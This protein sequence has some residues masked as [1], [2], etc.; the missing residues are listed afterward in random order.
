[1]ALALAQYE[2]IFLLIRDYLYGVRMACQIGYRIASV[3]LCIGYVSL[4]HQ[5]G[6][7]LH[8]FAE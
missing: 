1:M 8:Q 7:F 4:C 5:E 6:V 2:D 3:L